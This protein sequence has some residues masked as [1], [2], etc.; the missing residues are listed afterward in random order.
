MGR[1]TAWQKLN[2]LVRFVVRR[3][4]IEHF[5]LVD[6]GEGLDDEGIDAAMALG[7]TKEQSESALGHFGI[8]LKAASFSQAD[9]LT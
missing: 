2:T 5:V 4:L 8:G 3:G 7:K 6:D 9:E 1:V